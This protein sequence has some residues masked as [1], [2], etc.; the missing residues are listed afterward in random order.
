M[1]TLE[2]VPATPAAHARPRGVA[3]CRVVEIRTY[4]DGRGGLAFIEGDVAGGAAV[5]DVPFPIRRVYYAWG[6]EDDAV[7]GEHA[8]RALEQ[9]YL[10]VCG[11]FDVLLDVGTETR[12]VRLDRPNQ[13][14]YLGHM[15]WRRLE[16]FSAGS[17][18]LVLASAAFDE[19]DYFRDK[20]AFLRAA[21]A[22]R[23]TV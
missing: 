18:C 7:R 10:A 6:M 8:H 12:R 14:L 13:G 11:S 3:G 23:R 2:K 22:Q 19:A 5:A 9:V 21:A 17:V 4:K 20:D 15:V 16:N 1:T